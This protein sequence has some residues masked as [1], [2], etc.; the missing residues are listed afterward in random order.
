MPLQGHIVKETLG[1]ELALMHKKSLTA[2]LQGFPM[3]FRLIDQT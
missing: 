2:L 3:L 1:F